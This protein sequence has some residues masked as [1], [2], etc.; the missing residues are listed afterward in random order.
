MYLSRSV[1]EGFI[2][3]FGKHKNKNT[4]SLESRYTAIQSLL[5]TTMTPYCQMTTFAHDYMKKIF[6]MKASAS[7]LIK[8]TKPIPDDYGPKEKAAALQAQA[9]AS[10]KAASV[11]PPGET[12]EQA[13]QHI[14]KVYKDV[15]ACNDD[16]AS[17]RPSC[18]ESLIRKLQEKLLGHSAKSD[19]S[20]EFIPCST[21]LHL[22][23]WDNEDTVTPSAA[24]MLIPDDLAEHLTKEID[25][26]EAMLNKLSNAA[27]MVQSPPSSPPDT[28]NTPDSDSSGKSYSADGFLDKGKCSPSD[29]QARL[30]LLRKKKL[31]GKGSSCNIPPLEDE[32]DR[33]EALM[34]SGPL[35]SV[36]ARCPA[37]LE[38]MTQLKALMDKLEK[39]LDMN[40]PK[41][42]Y[43]TFEGGNR[44]DAL[45]FS[46]KQNQP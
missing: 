27:N 31:E 29:I 5:T 11:G 37:M 34:A 38:R 6:T 32:L 24:L 26:Y 8:P 2:F 46:I 10:E 44:A 45:T 4:G 33:I 23:K 12:S 42:D 40:M 9:S 43:K 21:F 28:S 36:L 30:A 15:Y 16:M 3:G 39:G 19:D 1:P 22:P 25:W 14:L 18:K 7:D 20:D 13:E 41:K 35:K 17:S